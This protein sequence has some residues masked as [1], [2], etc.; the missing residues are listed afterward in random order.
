MN[1]RVSSL[2]LLAALV[3]SSSAFAEL[4][5]GR[6]VMLRVD[7]RDDGDLSAQDLEMVLIDRKGGERVRLLRA[8]SRDDGEDV[9]SIM[10]FLS[11]ADVE[12][13]GFLTYDYDADRDDDQ[14]LYLPALRKT[15]RIATG[16]KSGSFMGSD[17]S[18][19]DLT[20][21]EVDA[22][23]WKLMKQIELGGHSVWQIEGIP[24]TK[25]EIDETG[26]TKM[27]VFVRKDIDVLVRAVYWM[28]KG[29]RLKYFDVKKLEQIDGIWV[30]TEM[31]M[32]T[33]KGKTTLHRTRMRSTNVSFGQTF[34][35][36]FFDVRQLEKGP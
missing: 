20:T 21:R 18:Y 8:Y 10:F 25:E 13:T 7:A 27:L 29:S 23:D 22:Y 17:F 14:W 2:A 6:D 1:V 33:R 24:K 4:P 28:K 16:D 26:Y 35:E 15:K 5:S 30:P 9:H 31:H 36:G 3:G 19:A 12:D 11:P 34:P 32:M